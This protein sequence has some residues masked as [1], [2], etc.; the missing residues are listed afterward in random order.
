MALPKIIYPLTVLTNINDDLLKDTT[1]VM[2]NFLWDNKPDKIKRKTII[3]DFKRGGLKMLD[4]QKFIYSLK[5][6]WI[7]RILDKTN[8][9]QWK[10]IYLKQLKKYGGELIFEC[11]INPKDIKLK[12]ETFLY[13]VIKS[14][15]EIK[16]T[17]QENI[18]TSSEII[19]N[20]SHI[21]VLNKTL[22]YENWLNNGIKYVKHI[23]NYEQ[24]CFYSF[25][26]LTDKYNVPNTDFLKYMSLVRCISAAWKTNLQNE[27]CP[28]EIELRDT[29]LF[30]LKKSKQR[31]R[32]LYNYQLNNGL[33]RANKIKCK[34]GK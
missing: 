15:F 14:W 29:L 22:F 8:Q 31:T 23:Y 16:K 24:N 28:N 10:N 1:K 7:P 13:D 18:S 21:K 30:K 11:N 17:K 3:Q 12:K 2:F 33:P 27:S 4:L 9:G 25:V 19:W 34:V 26:N 32:F 6:G 5:A 20:N